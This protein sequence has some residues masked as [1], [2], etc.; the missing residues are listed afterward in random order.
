MVRALRILAGVLAVSG[1][2]IVIGMFALSIIGGAKTGSAMPGGFAVGGGAIVGILGMTMIPAFM[3]Q[4]LA[5]HLERRQID[6]QHAELHE[7]GDRQQGD[8]SP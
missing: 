7:Q 4:N 8:G 6:R 5:D 1:G 3:L 2:V